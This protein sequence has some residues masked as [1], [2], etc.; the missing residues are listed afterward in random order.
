MA[1]LEVKAALYPLQKG[2]AMFRSHSLWTEEHR[3]RAVGGLGMG[4]KE[5]RCS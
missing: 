2:T 5:Q 1:A 4:R 3:I